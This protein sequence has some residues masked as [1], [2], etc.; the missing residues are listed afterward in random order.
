VHYRAQAERLG[1]TDPALKETI[2]AFRAD[3]LAH[4]QTAIEHGAT[5]ALGYE[6][7]SGIVKTGSRLAIW[8]STRL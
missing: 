3:E 2:E 6:L 8:L 4:R 5:D 7:I 1:N